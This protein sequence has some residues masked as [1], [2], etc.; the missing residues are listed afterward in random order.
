[1][2]AAQQKKL[3]LVLVLDPVVLSLLYLALRQAE[4]K[5]PAVKETRHTSSMFMLIKMYIELVH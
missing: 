1:M 4:N 2:E 3:A 5:R